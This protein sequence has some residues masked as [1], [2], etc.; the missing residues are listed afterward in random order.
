MYSRGRVINSLF[1]NNRLE[2]NDATHSSTREIAVTFGSG[3]MVLRNIV[4]PNE[5]NLVLAEEKNAGLNDTFD[6]HM[7]YPYGR[8]ATQS[9]L[10]FYWEN[11]V[12]IGLSTFQSK[13]KQEMLAKVST[14]WFVIQE[15]LF[16]IHNLFF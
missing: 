12:Y 13:T 8:G 11:E 2:Y 7:Y 14:N 9:K 15:K 10:S 6:Y 5:Q 4:K 16:S 3:N 1:E